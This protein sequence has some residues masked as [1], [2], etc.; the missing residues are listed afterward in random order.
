MDFIHSCSRATSSE[1]MDFTWG[2]SSLLQHGMNFGIFLSMEWM[3]RFNSHSPSSEGLYYVGPLSK[4]IGCQW[5]IEVATKPWTILCLCF[6]RVPRTTPGF[7]QSRP[8]WPEVRGRSKWTLCDSR[9][10]LT[11]VGVVLGFCFMPAWQVFP[12]WRTLHFAG[13]HNLL[14]PPKKELWNRKGRK[15]RFT[16]RRCLV[17][18]NRT[19]LKTNKKRQET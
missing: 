10:L 18:V 2:C 7:C 5:E 4:L 17:L 19:D 9:P 12:I 3:L 11:R 16:F 8:T 6:H 13:W 15:K 1:H 14:G